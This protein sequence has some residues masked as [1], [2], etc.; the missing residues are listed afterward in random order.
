M[1]GI[2]SADPRSSLKPHDPPDTKS[3]S[4][5]DWTRQELLQRAHELDISGRSSMTRSQLIDA[6]RDH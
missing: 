3:S 4:Y 5:D 6:L 1:A 2:A